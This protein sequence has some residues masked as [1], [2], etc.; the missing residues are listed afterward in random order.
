MKVFST[1]QCLLG[2]SPLWHEDTLYW[3]DIKGKEILAQ[4]FDEQY[5]KRYRVPARPSALGISGKES[6]IVAFDDGIFHFDCIS[7]QREF[8]S[9]PVEANPKNRANDGKVGGC[10]AAFCWTSCRSSRGVMG[11][12]SV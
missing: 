1:S 6:L 2:E 12:G 3:V 11:T 10:P 4:S 7:G 8:I 5:P 9:K